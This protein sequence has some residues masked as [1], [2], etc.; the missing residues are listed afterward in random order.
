[1]HNHLISA[2]QSSTPPIGI[3]RRIGPERIP[4]AILVIQRVGQEG[5]AVAA[6][7]VAGRVRV[8]R[9][10]AEIATELKDSSNQRLSI[11]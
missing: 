1:M 5:R 11:S 10:G 2:P 7:L 3:V 4:R 9:I 8:E 6:E